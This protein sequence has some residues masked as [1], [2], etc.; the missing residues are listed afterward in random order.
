MADKTQ[1]EPPTILKE[2]LTSANESKW[3]AE[4]NSIDPYNVTID[5]QN[6][7]SKDYSKWDFLG[8]TFANCNFKRCKFTG[9]ELQS[10][11]FLSCTFTACDFS[12]ILCK[13]IKNKDHSMWDKCK[14]CNCI[15]HKMRVDDTS[16]YSTTLEGCN[17]IGSK[18]ENSRIGI[19]NFLKSD[20]SD[21]SFQRTKFLEGM[22]WDETIFNKNTSFE[23]ATFDPVKYPVK[24][25][26]SDKIKL[27]SIAFNWN[28]IRFLSTIPLFE[29]AWI[30]FIA[31]L[32]II[33]AIH[34]LN[35]TQ[36]ISVIHYPVPIPQNML[37]IILSSML[38]AISSTIYRLM[39]PNIIQ[40][41]TQSQWVYEH[42]HP[43]PF[44]LVK[45]LAK[46]KWRY[47]CVILL[48]LGGFIAV[49]IFSIRLLRAIYYLYFPY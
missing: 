29:I 36:F 42:N 6:L 23:Q 40:D 49:I 31:S 13:S 33:N 45:T 19:T 44:Y 43:R 11:R 38:L 3:N 16:L 24:A 28:R 39:C 10:T 4:K 18:I 8:I 35:R 9:C 17:L 2:A 21:C 26:K 27:K 37:W 47:T 30:A 1:T 20:L 15:M 48:I 5:K 25:D 12:N 32:I 14:L 41:F 7:E 22:L 34:T 46:E